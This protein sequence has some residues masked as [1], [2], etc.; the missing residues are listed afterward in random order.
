M[1]SELLLMTMLQAGL[2]HCTVVVEDNGSLL[3]SLFM[4]GLVGSATHCVTMCAPFVLSQVTTRLEH[5]PFPRCR[6]SN[7]SADQ[8]CCLIIWGA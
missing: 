2:A 4:A 7:G 8:L 6:N 1:E 5:I 3:I